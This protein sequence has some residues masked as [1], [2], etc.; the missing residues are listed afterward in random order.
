MFYKYVHDYDNC[1]AFFIREEELR[2]I[3]DY[4]ELHKIYW[5]I[6]ADKKLCYKPIIRSII[7]SESIIR[8]NCFACAYA[9]MLRKYIV[10]RTFCSCCPIKQYRQTLSPPD[11][12]CPCCNR[13]PY[14]EWE[15]TNKPE[16]ARQISE[17]KFTEPDSQ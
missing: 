5:G 7:L 17:L 4:E 16:I 8:N 15:Q 6:I 3:K 10:G 11:D 1:S 13:G 14:L 9:L 12:I 2:T